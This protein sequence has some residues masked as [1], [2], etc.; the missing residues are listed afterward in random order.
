MGG[1][2]DNVEVGLRSRPCVARIW[3]LIDRIIDGGLLVPEGLV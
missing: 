3:W 1:C 2:E